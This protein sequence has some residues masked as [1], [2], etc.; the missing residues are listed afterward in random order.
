MTWLPLLLKC[1]QIFWTRSR[2]CPVRRLSAAISVSLSVSLSVCRSV[3]ITATTAHYVTD[4]WRDVIDP[5]RLLLTSCTAGRKHPACTIHQPPPA[6]WQRSSYM[7]RKSLL[8]NM[9]SC[10]AHR[11][12][13]KTSY[14]FQLQYQQQLAKFHWPHTSINVWLLIDWLTMGQTDRW[15][16]TRPMFT[17]PRITDCI[18]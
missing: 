6:D 13:M 5:S 3:I 14:A 15:P 18:L 10:R 17:L 16:D 8:W 2:L 7:R 11:L 1:V 12:E 9:E 4:T